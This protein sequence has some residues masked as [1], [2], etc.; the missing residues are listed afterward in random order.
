MTDEQKDALNWARM[1]AK[2][3]QAPALIEVLAIIAE[4]LD[5]RLLS[6]QLWMEE[7][8]HKGNLTL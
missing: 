5:D 7:L 6:I 4:I 2:E 3:Q 1:Q 8:K